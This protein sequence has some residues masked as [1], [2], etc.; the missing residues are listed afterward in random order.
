M[1][2]ER[3]AEAL[4]EAFP[5]MLALSPADREACAKDIVDAARFQ[6]TAWEETSTAVATGLGSADLEWLDEEDAAVQ[7]AAHLLHSPANAR[8]L[9]D[10][11]DRARAP[12]MGT[13]GLDRSDEET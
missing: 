7:E 13:H 5:W 9:L 10:A 4:P 12:R 6:L 3:L 11:S 8:R 2:Y 1:D